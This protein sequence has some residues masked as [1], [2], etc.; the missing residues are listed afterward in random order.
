MGCGPRKGKFKGKKPA[1]SAGTRRK[2]TMGVTT[3]EL[4]ILASPHCP[5]G[6]RE[7]KGL[8]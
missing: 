3:R 8:V 1:A 5:I 4:N 7:E 6:K 2:G